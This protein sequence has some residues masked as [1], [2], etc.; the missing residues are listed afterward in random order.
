MEN[1]NPKI[2]IG[3]QW[4][5][6]GKGKIVDFL[7]E[8]SS[9]CVRFQGGANA[10]HTIK[11]DGET[12][13]L[14]LSPSGVLRGAN[15]LLASNVVVDL[16]VLKSEV[17][18]LNRKIY[19]DK[20]ATIVLPHY[21]SVDRKK[22]EISQISTTK[23][24]IGIAYSDKATRVALRMEDLL[25]SKSELEFKLIAIY[26]NHMFHLETNDGFDSKI[27]RLR[28]DEFVNKNLDHLS[29]MGDL[30]KDSIVDG[31]EVIQ[32]YIMDGHEVIFE[33]AQGTLLDL[34][35]GTYPYVTSSNTTATSVESSIGCF[36]PKS[37]ER[38]GVFKAYCT[39]V[40]NGEFEGELTD[41]IGDLI[42]QKGGEVGV[43]TGRKRR[44]GWLSLPLLKYAQRLNGFDYL[45]MTKADVLDGFEEVKLIGLD[46]T[47]KSFV[48]WDNTQGKT[49]EDELDV[50]FI[51]YL[52]Y[53]ESE[54]GLKVKIISTGAERNQTIIR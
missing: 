15:G 42:Q 48:G 19:V 2:I 18:S 44:C 8:N 20:K 16:E 21:K 38:I 17:E 5:D 52:R 11:F 47:L 26:S 46:G 33:G 41:E 25:L 45:A 51:A 3:T 7:S 50:R 23:N 31:G 49:N 22:D 1:V 12:F 30:F 27:R 29:S 14:R 39:R 9:L 10:G 24:G 36:L 40:G 32:N 4:G 53:I 35:H 37:T 43:V 54:I 34:T 6:E 13:K 28:L